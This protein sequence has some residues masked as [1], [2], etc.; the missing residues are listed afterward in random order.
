MTLG[1]AEDCVGDKNPGF[2]LELKRL[3]A[4]SKVTDKPGVTRASP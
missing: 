2:D 3:Q 1:K 4:L